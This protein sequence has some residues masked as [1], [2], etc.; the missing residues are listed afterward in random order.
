MQADLQSHGM[1]NHVTIIHSYTTLI[2]MHEL[3]MHEL[4]CMSCMGECIPIRVV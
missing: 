1:Q 3:G 2:G 4:G